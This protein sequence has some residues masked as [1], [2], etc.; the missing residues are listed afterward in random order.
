M[1]IYE[2]NNEIRIPLGNLGSDDYAHNGGCVIMV[3]KI[4]GSSIRKEW[5]TCDVCHTDF[6]WL[7]AYPVP[8]EKGC[9]YARCRNCRMNIRGIERARGSR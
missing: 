9:Y 7:N 5:V 3:L 1:V 2:K 6:V 4:V 8:F